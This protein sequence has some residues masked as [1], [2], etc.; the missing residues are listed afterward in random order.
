MATDPALI[1]SVGVG[2]VEVTGITAFPHEDT[3]ISTHPTDPT[4]PLVHME[5]TV[6]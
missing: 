1:P 6:G 5:S 4:L 3:V 2:S